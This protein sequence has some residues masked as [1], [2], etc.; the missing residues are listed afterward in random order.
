MTKK[1]EIELSNEGIPPK[2]NFIIDGRVYKLGQNP[3]IDI[4]IGMLLSAT[5]KVYE[6]RTRQDIIIQTKPRKPS[7]H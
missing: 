6:T 4:E 7:K 1:I 3:S 5:C 2:M